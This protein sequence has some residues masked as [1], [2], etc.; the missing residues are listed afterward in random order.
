[1]PT[2]D[3]GTPD[4]ELQARLRTVLAE[5]DQLEMLLREREHDRREF[6][7]TLAHELR[8]PLAAMRSAT[9]VLRV[10]ENDQATASVARGMIE[11]QLA[12]MVRLIDDLADVACVAQERFELR[13]EPVSLAV[14]LEQAVEVHHAMLESRRQHLHL[15]VPSQP[16]WLYVDRRRMVQVFASIINNSSKFSDPGTAI[17]IHASRDEQHLVVTVTDYG[18]GI[19]E[20]VLPHVFDMFAR[21]GP[22]NRDG[23]IGL[24]VGMTLAKRLV[25]LH[26]G[27]IYV[28]SDGPGQGSTFVVNLNL[29]NVPALRCLPA[30][31]TQIPATAPG[32]NLRGLTHD[33]HR[34]GAL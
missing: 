11:R 14:L 21:N 29:V 5:R 8:N 34:D 18:A 10:A 24:G 12:Q 23:Q 4:W 27:R 33:D 2:N 19:G 22:V 6:F 7:A 26:G 28:H 31:Q 25:E 17:R 3:A 16:V 1:M 30:T 20:D 32:G 15:E 13:R 9:H